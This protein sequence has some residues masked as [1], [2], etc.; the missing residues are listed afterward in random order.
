MTGMDN[1][2]LK[3][4]LRKQRDEFGGFHYAKVMGQALQR[5]EALEKFRDELL[6]E[7]HSL[8]DKTWALSSAIDK[9]RDDNAELR[10]RMESLEK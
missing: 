7:N 3:D 4:Y 8:R 5:I 10:F 9:L 6:T 1:D 2:Q